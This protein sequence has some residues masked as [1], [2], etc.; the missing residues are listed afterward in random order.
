MRSCESQRCDIA[1]IGISCEFPGG[2]NIDEYWDIISR[3]ICVTKL[4]GAQNQGNKIAAEGILKTPYCFDAHYFNINPKDAEFMDPQL[5]KLLEHAVKS[6]QDANVVDNLT[7]NNIGAFL[8]VGAN[9]YLHNCLM[10]GG[11]HEDKNNHYRLAIGNDKNCVAT[12]VAYHLNLQGPALTISTACS[13]SL[14]AIHEACKSLLAGESHCALAGGATV[15]TP[16]G[17]GYEYATGGVLS[18]KGECRPFSS[19]SDG[20]IP[21]SGIG[22]VVLKRLSDALADRDN[23]Y[24]VIKGSAVNNDGAEKVGY[25]APSIQGQAKVIEQALENSAISASDIEYIEC[26]GTGTLLGDPIEIEALASAYEGQ[27]RQTC[28][29]GSVKWNIGHTDSAAGVAGFIKAV[30]SLKYNMIIGSPYLSEPNPELGLETSPFYI[31]RQNKPFHGQEPKVAIS[32]FGMGGTNCHLIL[33]KY[34]VKTESVHTENKD[35]LCLIPFSARS[36]TSLDQNIEQLIQFVDASESYTLGNIAGTLIGCRAEE[37]VRSFAV[38]SSLAELTAAMKTERVVVNARAGVELVVAVEGQGDQV[39]GAAAQYYQQLHRFR[40]HFDTCMALFLACEG[41]PQDLVQVAL[42]TEMARDISSQQTLYA[43]PILFSTQYAIARMLEEMGLRFAGFIGHSLGEWIAAVIAGLWD[44][45]EAVEL[46][47]LRA[48]EL[49]RCQDG[50]MAVFFTGA[51]VLTPYLNGSLSITG[52]NGPAMTVVAGLAEDLAL[53]MESL[54]EKRIKSKRLNTNK[55]F[56]HPLIMPAIEPLKAKLESMTFQKASGW[57]YSN[58]TGERMAW[59]TA[60]TPA[61]WLQQLLKPVKM[62]TAIEHI[63]PERTVVVDLGQNGTM[64]Q[65]LAAN[66]PELRERCCSVRRITCLAEVYTLIGTVWAHGASINWRTFLPE[67][68][69]KL[70]LPSYVFDSNEYF[71]APT[72]STSASVAL[73]KPVNQWLYKEAWCIDPVG[74]FNKT[75]NHLSSEQDDWYRD[76]EV[77]IYV[78]FWH[79]TT[80]TPHK[81]EKFLQT[82]STLGDAIKQCHILV[83]YSS[84]PFPGD[85]ADCYMGALET[86]VTV[87]NQ[88]NQALSTRLYNIT[89]DWSLEQLLHYDLSALSPNS[90]VVYFD[91]AQ[92]WTKK[93]VPYAGSDHRQYQW[94]DDGFILITGGLGN[95]GLALALYLTSRTQAT[96]I[97]MGRKGAQSGHLALSEL[98]ESISS[99]IQ[100]RYAFDQ[101][102]ENLNVYYV[103]QSIEDESVADGV[104]A[105]LVSQ[106]GKLMGIVHCAGYTAVAGLR[107]VLNETQD[108]IERHYQPKILGTQILANICETYRPD[109]CILMSS[110]STLLGG[111]GLGLYGY[112]NGFMNG[113]SWLKRADAT[114]WMSISWD[115][116]DLNDDPTLP[117]SIKLTAIGRDDCEAIFDEVFSHLHMSHMV[118]S[119][120]SLDDRLSKWVKGESATHSV[121]KVNPT[122]TADEIRQKVRE[123]FCSILGVTDLQDQSNFFDLG[124]QSVLFTELAAEIRS[125]LGLQLPLHKFINEP[126]VDNITRLLVQEITAGNWTKMTIR[127]PLL[128]LIGALLGINEIKMEDNFFDLGGNSLLFTQLTSQIKAQF[129]FNLP[130]HEFINQPTVN[131][132]AD[133]IVGQ[134]Q[135]PDMINHYDVILPDDYQPLTPVTEQQNSVYLVTGAAGL[136]GVNIVIALLKQSNVKKV[137]A[138]VRA[139]NT[140]QAYQRVLREI[141]R[142]VSEDKIS[143]NK[144]QVLCGDVTHPHFGLND[145]DYRAISQEATDIIHNAAHVHHILDYQSLKSTNT[146]SMVSVIELAGTYQAKRIHFISTL[147]CAFSLSENNQYE[148]VLPDEHVYPFGKANGYARSKWAAERLLAQAK[149]RGFSV[150]VIRPSSIVGDT[151]TGMFNPDN[152]HLWLFIKGCLQ[153]GTYPEMENEVNMSPVDF[154]A[155]LVVAICQNNENKVYNIPNPH[156][157]QMNDIF[158]YLKNRGY[159]LMPLSHEA[160]VDTELVKVTKD[161]ALYPILSYYTYREEAD[162]SLP[163]D[164]HN[165]E[166]INTTTLIQQSEITYPHPDVFL[167]ALV[168]YLEQV[169]FFPSQPM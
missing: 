140:D 64:S 9:H 117:A 18:E 4:Q 14:V 59:R 96:I 58:L 38:A 152:D 143:L 33:S 145:D 122:I 39:S 56:H 129:N 37:P 61:Y 94:Q 53:L 123:I 6:L 69:S 111:M 99:S 40:E 7:E 60:S 161:N 80:L 133:M 128:S 50:Q 86:L 57:L 162:T 84:L 48:V 82:V 126:T 20:T 142:F 28:A 167:A 130:L 124:G 54:R 97:L 144:L 31:P 67:H 2:Q 115:G 62:A 41:I 153:L 139:D 21:S 92:A 91:G 52:F 27:H 87:L 120:H 109:F 49:Q 32:S 118:V 23:I 19:D 12:Q 81:I 114:Q 116:W 89:C 70:R 103:S 107:P 3:N 85:L 30:L 160:W 155:R 113:Y 110:I 151:Q 154:V 34:S 51:D 15:L 163:H 105:G 13:S 149:A 159:S 146:D 169:A 5:R 137:Y 17:E 44:L 83:R 35:S 156:V 75:R 68:W 112:V 1:V 72:P 166:I 43:Q 108:N 55:A 119:T 104:I 22:I 125:S 24:A 10:K 102:R 77:A 135:S 164:L 8:S 79:K 165:V 16:H 147:A 42:D 63:N 29:I 71:M 78:G 121:V 138:L 98:P 168:G 47:A 76:G 95:I 90:E 100:N 65:L 88:E 131:A 134:S 36:K 46:I 25:T 141:A 101:L 150:N 74:S 132:L 73:K 45:R 26:H 66:Q 136:L 148:E 93:Y 158:V 157:I 127:E 106:F 11:H